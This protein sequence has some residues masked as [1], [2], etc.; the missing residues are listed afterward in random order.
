MKKSYFILLAIFIIIIIIIVPGYSLVNKYLLNNKTDSTST[1]S[2]STPVQLDS[3]KEATHLSKVANTSGTYWQRQFDL[4]WEDAEPKKGQIDWDPIDQHIKETNQAEIYLVATVKPYANWDQ[5][6]CH[7][8]E[9]RSDYKS[10]VN[11]E[12]EGDNIKV[13]KPCDMNA[14]TNFLSQA[15]ERYDGDGLNDM[16]GLTIPL[17]YWEIMNEPSMQGGSTGGM[18][19]E[20]KFFVGSSQD[21]LEI[22]TNSYQAIKGADSEAQV[23]QGGMAG[24]QQDFVDFWDPILKAGGGQYFD[25]ANNHSISTDNRR[26]DLYVTRFKQ[27][28]KKYNLDDKPIWITELQIGE[29]A[30]PPQDIKEF[31]TLLFKASI[32]PL[33]KGADKLFYIDNWTFWSNTK[34]DKQP[35]KQPDSKDQFK[36]DFSNGK[37]GKQLD[38]AILESST[39]K[40]YLNLVKHFNQFNSI[41]TIKEETIKPQSDSDGLQVV[42][43]QY[44]FDTTGGDIYILWGKADL[45]SQ[46]KNKTQVKTIDLYGEESTVNPQQITLSSQPVIII[47]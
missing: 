19:E 35:P 2:G 24:M 32:V 7:G 4:Y 9:Y 45:P 47:P 8:E 15:V 17:K 46:L 27:Y 25:I 31:D 6:S 16:P 41:T 37:N 5:D 12:A 11:P 20:L 14:Y 33:A 39:H 42:V 43:G 40:V 21:Y 34:P 18:G 1:P 22:L 44:K 29:L 23:V 10:M 36:D 3:Q 28:L 13:G 26:H 30:S 38:P